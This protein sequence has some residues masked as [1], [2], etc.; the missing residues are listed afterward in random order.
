M[1]IGNSPIGRR[2]PIVNVV[3]FNLESRLNSDEG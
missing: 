2:V 3:S 1:V